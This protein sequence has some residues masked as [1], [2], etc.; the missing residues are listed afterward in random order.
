MTPPELRHASP[1]AAQVVLLCAAVTA[2]RW[3]ARVAHG[4]AGFGI[5]HVVSWRGNDGIDKRE[6]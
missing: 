2:S 3:V 4:L 6:H 1:L 5:W